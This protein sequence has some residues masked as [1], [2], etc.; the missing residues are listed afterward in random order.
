MSDFIPIPRGDR[1]GG[2]RHRGGGRGRW[3]QQQ[4]H[5]SDGN[6]P[7]GRGRGGGSGR[8]GR[9]RGGREGRPH[10]GNVGRGG[11]I[12]RDYDITNDPIEILGKYSTTTLN[13]AIEGCCHGELDPI[14]DRLMAH[15][16]HSGQKVDLLIC[17]GDFQSFR[18]PNDFHSCSMPPKYRRLGSFPRYYSG[19]KKA[20]I[21]TLFIGGNHEA[22]QPLRELYYG[23][24]AAPNI[25]YLGVAGV[26]RYGGLRI[27]GISG[28][29]KS[30]DY[31]MGHYGT[32]PSIT[33]R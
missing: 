16:R 24:W 20:P 4:H 27:G 21:L 23:G 6:G 8:N 29:Y 18:N 3:N 9:G 32:F 5:R 17:C 28:I 19:E 7:G 1:G 26:V 25:Y 2:G 11:M 13:I 10:H 33:W 31:P 30:H 15:E 12:P 22:S 14:Y